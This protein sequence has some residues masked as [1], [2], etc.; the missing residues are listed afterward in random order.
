MQSNEPLIERLI[1]AEEAAEYLGFSSLT[2]RRMAHEGRLPSVPFP[3]G[4]GK[5]QHRFYMSQLRSYVESLSH[6]SGAS[7]A[8]QAG[9]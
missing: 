7:D 5:F 6:G 9:M 8:N 2:V 4:R 3:R 1:G